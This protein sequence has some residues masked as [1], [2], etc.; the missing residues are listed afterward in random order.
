MIKGRTFAQLSEEDR[1]KI[2]ALLQQGLSLSAVARALCRSVSTISREVKRNGPVKY[3]ASRAHSF[4]LTRHRQKHKH[5]VFD[6]AMIDFIEL[7]LC[8]NKWSPELISVA[9]RKWRTDFIS[10]EWVYQWIWKMKFSM[11]ISD[12]K[13]QLLYKSLKH[14]SRRRKRGRKRNM[15]GNIIG[16]QW[17]DSR[18]AAAN[19]RRRQ[20]DLEADIILGKDRKPGLLVALDRKTRKVWIRK[21]KTKDAGYVINKLRRIC[22]MIGKVKTVTLDNDQ[23]FAEHYRLNQMAI[24]TFFTHPYSSQEKGSVE[25]RIGVIRRFFGKKTD[26]SQVKEA[27][28]QRVE[29][30]INQRP[31]RMFNYKS[32]NEIYI[33]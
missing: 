13:Y 3:R 25:N 7:N 15:R 14:G 4:T 22:S 26:F 12:K 27:E 33:S 24:N 19:Q 21:L 28:V 17:I 6:Q 10:H 1:I 9:G 2:E 18:P 32:P 16:R 23:S 5:T 20:G 30:L 31:L 29:S 11:A 8:K